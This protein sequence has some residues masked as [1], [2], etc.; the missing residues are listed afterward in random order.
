LKEVQNDQ[1]SGQKTRDAIFELATYLIASA[2]DCLE[3]PA[4]YGPLRMVVG[5]QK[6]IEMESLNSQLRDEFLKSHE[7]TLGQEVLAVMSDREAFSNAL[8]KLLLAFSDEMNDRL[9]QEK[10]DKT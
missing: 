6:I 5:V 10:Q 4:I 3:E 2:R 7:E 8:D 1:L 9:T